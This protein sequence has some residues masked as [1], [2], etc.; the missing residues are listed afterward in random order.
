MAKANKRTRSRKIQDVDG[1]GSVR[2]YTED[3]EDISL[4]EGLATEEHPIVAFKQKGHGPFVIQV[5]AHDLQEALR[6]VGL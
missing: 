3:H 1:Y 6:D 2:I 4:W 5:K